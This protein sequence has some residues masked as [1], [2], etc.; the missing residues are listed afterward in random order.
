MVSNIALST[1]QVPLLA[2]SFQATTN[3]RPHDGTAEQKCRGRQVTATRDMDNQS[4]YR[5][6]ITT[7]G[8]GQIS[9]SPKHANK[10]HAPWR[11]SPTGADSSP[12]TPPRHAHLLQVP[13]PRTHRTQRLDR[14]V[15]RGVHG[16]GWDHLLTPSAF[17]RVRTNVTHIQKAQRQKARTTGLS[18]ASTN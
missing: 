16:R 11:A 2:R 5:M 14:S 13:S 3:P 1:K 15:G 18:A 4:D 6:P 9:H 10:T 12:F 7:C 8:D 17:R